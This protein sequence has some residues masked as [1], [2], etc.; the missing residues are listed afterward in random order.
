MHILTHQ[1]ATVCLGVHG[2]WTFDAISDEDKGRFEDVL[3]EL[4]ILVGDCRNILE[5]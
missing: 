1:T 5:L 3:R 4:S 2:L